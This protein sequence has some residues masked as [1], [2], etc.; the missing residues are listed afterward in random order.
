M[1]LT[2]IFQTQ[3][4]SKSEGKIEKGLI[5][6][7][8]IVYP[9]TIIFLLGNCSG[10]PMPENNP[11]NVE[12][13]QIHNQKE[14]LE[15]LKSQ[16]PVLRRQAVLDCMENTTPDCLPILREL[17]VKDPDPGVRSVTA[18]S[19]GE[20]KDKA[21]IAKII[22]LKK[23]PDIFPDTILDALTRMGD[24]Q[25]GSAILDYLNS[26]DHGVRLLTV[27]AFRVIQAKDQAPK[28]LK[29][30]EVNK[31]SEKHKT[32]AMAL[33]VLEYKPSEEYLI[34][35]VKKEEDGPT[36]A[37]ALLA[38][39]K[40]KSTK[41]SSILLE[42]LVS[43]YPKGRENSYLSLKEIKDP[44]I[45]NQLI[46]VWEN[47]D[48][49]LRFLT[50]KIIA[51]YPPK[52]YLT[53]IRSILREKKP[54]SIGP[55]SLVL[56]EWKDL[57]SR[58]FIE[59][60]LL[61]TNSPDREELAQ[62][63]GWIGSNE[64]EPTLWKVLSEKEGMARYGAAWALGFAGGEKSVPILIEA[65]RSK[66]KRL[67]SLSIESLGQLKSPSS[68]QALLI[69][70]NDDNLAAFAISAI[71][72]IPTDEARLE[73]EKMAKSSKNIQSKLAIEAIGQRKDKNSIPVLK[74]LSLSDNPEIRKMAKFALKTIELSQK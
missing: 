43:N 32:F 39:G 31:D 57:D 68:L 29:L 59:S 52:P 17:V 47:Q 56:G 20:Y 38:L 19:L 9:L 45:M 49:E 51:S 1:N 36:K 35:L 33:G 61:N 6:P 42:A 66:D 64:S 63:L 15:D 50:S 12:I 48:R 53:R 4:N 44:K 40:V 34:G 22:S 11:P 60:L 23:D 55:A 71:S 10:P 30:A 16:N 54:T 26:T 69:S 67:A 2:K 65:S 27:E 62:A 3:R 73:L 70:S 8:L 18:V 5:R 14:I 21:S 13:A 37:A 74:E 28:I 24:V 46:S 7:F 72:Q 58:K 41:S 25:A